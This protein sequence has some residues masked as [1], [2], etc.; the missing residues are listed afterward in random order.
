MSFG[1][2]GGGHDGGPRPRRAQ[3]PWKA[4]RKC[5]TLV[6]P[7]LPILCFGLLSTLAGV[8]LGQQPPRIYQYTID[9]IIGAGQYDRLP[10][11]I[12]IYVGI[13]IAGQ[14][15]SSISGFWM[16]VAGQRLLHSLRMALYDH[17]QALTLRYFDDKRTGDLLS[18]V[19]GDVNSV[20]GMIINTTN[21]LLRQV[22]GI[23]FAVYYMC[24]YNPHLTM[25]VLIPVPILGVAIYFFTRRIRM[26]YRAIRDAA[27]QL[28]AK[29]AE[30]LS[31][32]RVIK[33]FSR[34]PIEHEQVNET[35]TYLLDANIKASRMTSLFYPAIHVV[36][37][38]GT[39]IVLGVGAYL[40]SKGEFT[41][42]ALTAFTMYVGN[43]YNPIGDFIRTLDS[44]Q[45]ALASGERIFEVLDSVPEIQ[46]PEHPLP[47]TSVRGEVELCNVSFRYGSG[48]EVLRGVD[49]LA[50]PGEVIA[51]VGQSGAGKT[52]LVNLIPRFYDVTE[53][54]VKVDGIDVREVTQ[55]DLRRHIAMVLQETFLFNGTVRENLR[56]GRLE[57]T[58]EELEAAARAGNADEFIAN[59]PDGYDTEIGERGVKLSGG[60]KQRLAI[61]RAVLANPRILILDEATSS[62]D[63]AAECLIHQALDR[64]MRGR[65]TFIIAHRLSTV[66]AASQILVLHNGELVERGRHDELVERDGQYAAMCRQQF[67]LNTT[68]DLP[69]IN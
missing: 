25:L 47:L 52:S 21:S 32:I 30:N 17:F 60:Q 1:G 40:I 35:S 57:A 39:V 24:H 14:A 10:M 48:D 56:F 33:A 8:Y 65:T 43:F 27:G 11:T 53:G 4:F 18:R 49:I 15:I 19:T 5:L 26:V 69:A 64:L 7:L 9:N 66:R 3:D 58:D 42:G 50:Q 20:E 46:D 34:E 36:S 12:A 55:R 23:G 41:I 13:I 29:L 28:S 67:W 51:L 22:C 37:A 2:R 31:G 61:A 45:R 62:V 54:Q 59:L 63:S 44:I 68:A 38:S 6:K 16:S